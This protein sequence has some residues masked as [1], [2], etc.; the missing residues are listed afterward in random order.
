MANPNPDNQNVPAPTATAM[1]IGR[2]KA[3]STARGQLIDSIKGGQDVRMAPSG[4]GKIKPT[5]HLINS[6]T[7]HGV[8]VCFFPTL[9]TVGALLCPLGDVF[10]KSKD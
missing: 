8:N 1:M 5:E 10:P 6:E 3:I 2:L 9:L 4:S 7:K